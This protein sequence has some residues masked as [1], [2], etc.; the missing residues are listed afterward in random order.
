MPAVVQTTPQKA[1]ASDGIEGLDQLV[2]S[3][4]R[5]RPGIPEG[6]QARETVGLYDSEQNKHSDSCHEQNEHLFSVAAAD[7][8]Q[9]VSH[10]ADD[11]SH[12]HVGLEHDQTADHADDQKHGKHAVLERMH[13][14][15]L[16]AH[17]GAHVQHHAE[18][19]DLGWLDTLSGND[20]PAL[21]S[22]D[23]PAEYQNRD[24]KND[25]DKET[26]DL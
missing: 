21:A 25:G 22:V 14:F 18:F 20:Q 3:A 7:E 19:R 10:D 13:D 16:L 4:E 24:E 23:L 11:N 17:E 12:G 1:A 6:G 2:A 9:R 8:Q 26:D 15:M 5:I